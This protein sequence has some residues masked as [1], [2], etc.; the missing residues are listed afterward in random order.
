MVHNPRFN[1]QGMELICKLQFKVVLD[2]TKKAK[3]IIL[4]SSF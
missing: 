1:S 4:I 3:G 2:K